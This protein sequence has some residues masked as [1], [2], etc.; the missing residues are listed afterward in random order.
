MM[1]M[2][3]FEKYQKMSDVELLGE[4]SYMEQLGTPGEVQLYLINEE[5]EKRKAERKAQKQ[6]TK[7]NR[8]VRFSNETKYYEQKKVISST[9]SSTYINKD[10]NG[11][12]QVG[13]TFPTTYPEATATVVYDSNNNIKKIACSGRGSRSFTKE[14]KSMATRYFNEK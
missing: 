3:I 10:W 12:Y 14:I 6:P 11:L 7:K 1:N 13:M 5:W 2:T 4:K 9:G 8:D